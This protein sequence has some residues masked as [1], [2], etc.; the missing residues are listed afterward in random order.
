[1]NGLDTELNII[2]HKPD[3]RVTLKNII[4]VCP[5]VGNSP[6]LRILRVNIIR[7]PKLQI[8]SK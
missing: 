2:K 4:V 7:T 5:I 8:N 6:L 3:T 1:M